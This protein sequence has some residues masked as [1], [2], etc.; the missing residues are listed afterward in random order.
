MQKLAGG[1]VLHVQALRRM[2]IRW[3]RGAKRVSRLTRDVDLAVVDLVA[4][5]S[6]FSITFWAYV[7]HGENRADGQLV[8]PPFTTGSFFYNRFVPGA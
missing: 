6:S 2:V 1:R 8:C 7:S 3:H 5:A 4:V